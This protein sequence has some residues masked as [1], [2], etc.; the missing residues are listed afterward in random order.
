ETIPDRSAPAN[1]RDHR[2][3]RRNTE[4]VA[5]RQD[6]IDGIYRPLD[7]DRTVDHRR[8]A[9]TYAGADRGPVVVYPEF[10]ADT[11]GNPCDPTR[12]YRQPDHRGLR[13][14]F[15]CRRADNRV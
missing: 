10:W 15:I 1:H 14:R 2:Y 6:R 3:H 12:V 9:R 11:V 4:V 5:G 8:A 7:M 13:H